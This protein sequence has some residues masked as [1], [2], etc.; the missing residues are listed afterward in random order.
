MSARIER[1]L[2]HGE[3][4]ES[5]EAAVREMRWGRDA[6]IMSRETINRSGADSRVFAAW[7]SRGAFLAE[8]ATMGDDERCYHE[9]IPRG[10]PQRLRYDI[11]V[12]KSE[13]PALVAWYESLAEPAPAAEP[14]AE[15]AVEPAVAEPVP[16]ELAELAEWLG[17]VPEPAERPMRARAVEAAHCLLHV[18]MRLTEAAI[19]AV[20][21][22]SF[23]VYSSCGEHKLSYH[24]HL[25]RGH[26]FTAEYA[27]EIALGVIGSLEPQVTRL[28]DA[29]IYTGTSFRFVGS[30]KRGQARFKRCSPELAQLFGTS[31]VGPERSFIESRECERLLCGPGGEEDR[32]PDV[33]IDDEHVKAIVGY[34]AESGVSNG[35]DFNEAFGSL[36]TFTRL[37]PSHC[38]LCGVT[39]DRDNTLMVIVQA[40]GLMEKCRHAPR[41]GIRIA[42][43][44]MAT[45]AGENKSAE[46]VV[47]A[48]ASVAEAVSRRP[49][50]SAAERQKRYADLI[51]DPAPLPESFT[52]SAGAP[53][54]EVYC[55]ATRPLDL[56]AHDIYAIKVPCGGGKT[57]S[58]LRDIAEFAELNPTWRVVAVTARRTFADDLIA[59]AKA[60]GLE[61]LS[62][63]QLPKVIS[64]YTTN[65]VVVQYESLPRLHGMAA[66]RGRTLVLL[67]EWHSLARQMDSQLPDDWSR[68]RAFEELCQA[69][70]V[71]AMDA[72][73]AD[74]FAAALEAYVARWPRGAGEAATPRPVVRVRNSLA[75]H[76]AEPV[77]LVMGPNHAAMKRAVDDVK[78]GRCITASFDWRRDLEAFTRLLPADTPRVILTGGDD[79]AKRREIMSDLTAHCD[80]KQARVVAWTSTMEHG[81]SLRSPRFDTHYV[82]GRATLDTEASM[83]MMYR[84][85]HAKK[86]VVSWPNRDAAALPRHTAETVFVELTSLSRAT[87]SALPEGVRQAAGGAFLAKTPRVLAYCAVK[88]SKRNSEGASLRR[89]MSMLRSNGHSLFTLS[90]GADAPNEFVTAQLHAEADG[91]MDLARAM[92]AAPLLGPTALSEVSAKPE[93]TA[94]E[95]LSYAH[96]I[97]ANFYATGR[98]MTPEEV[99]TYGPIRRRAVMRE[100]RATAAPPDVL[101]ELAATASAMSRDHDSAVLSSAMDHSG[102]VTAHR[103]RARDHIL[104]LVG[105]TDYAAQAGT[106]F[107]SAQLTEN[108]RRNQGEL[109]RAAV[110]GKL[111][112]VDGS[113]CSFSS[114]QS[115][116]QYVKSLLAGIGLELEESRK[117]ASGVRGME[118]TLRRTEGWGACPW[119]MPDMS[120]A[121]RAAFRAARSRTSADDEAAYLLNKSAASVVMSD[122]SDVC[123][124]DE[125]VRSGMSAEE[126]AKFDSDAAAR[127]VKVQ[128]Y[129]EYADAYARAVGYESD[130]PSLAAK[131][132]SPAPERTN[133]DLVPGPVAPRRG[134]P[135]KAEKAS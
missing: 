106:T 51:A 11:D 130:P 57:F 23:A 31:M 102:L 56:D 35:F 115:A 64:L 29:A 6:V 59:T 26:A 114:W 14:A 94:E 97:A 62:Y 132:M 119:P 95:K 109:L 39:H 133:A 78:A 101:V 52:V 80:E 73:M 30:S 72:Y 5:I 121:G 96:T 60:H 103:V 100:M 28:V 34:L 77:E 70:K 49:K 17:A 20:S 8:Y 98:P 61:F 128:R 108:V 3:G 93:K 71:I 84:N 68:T 116:R 42:L 88:A 129:K 40:D 22:D 44:D 50:L 12:A 24:I 118:Y 65:Y 113:R 13:W 66:F 91:E 69:Q 123:G 76:A 10:R 74:D 41:G 36:L 90:Q 105:I 21:R 86:F 25:F 1:P 38:R 107:T 7:P 48:V 75:V 111:L 122:G 4:H 124:L 16:D 37:F 33:E 2:L 46:A 9:I 82:F 67:D 110:A 134:R 126:A 104:S 19:P 125:L 27:R 135:P 89:L 32:A 55:E 87:L 85:R 83:Q 117:Q 45:T 112:G 18:V 99:L 63:T 58:G 15:P 47:S 43:P 79:D 127:A 54:S 131:A 81:V 53:G 120:A 92:A